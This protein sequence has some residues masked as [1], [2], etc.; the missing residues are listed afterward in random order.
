MTLS[1]KTKLRNL[2]FKILKL[3][4][5]GV[6]VL[7]INNEKFL[8]VKHSYAPMWYL[9][10]GGVDSG[11]TALAAVKR[12]LFEEVGIICDQFTLFNLYHNKREGHDDH[13]AMYIAHSASEQHQID[14]KEI[15]FASWFGFDE[16]PKDISPATKRRI[17]EYLEK[18]EKIDRW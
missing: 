17:E 6:R 16:L 18:S 10:G 3:K 15:S 11:E 12:E 4:T 5:V 2:V 9:P 14:N 13:V 8:L 1:L 7:L